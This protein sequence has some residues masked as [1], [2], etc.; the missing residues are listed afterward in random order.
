MLIQVFEEVAKLLAS[1]QDKESNELIN[2]AT[3]F[4]EECNS[5]SDTQTHREY[6]WFKNKQSLAQ[7]KIDDFLEQSSKFLAEGR[8][9]CKLLWHATVLDVLKICQ[10]ID[11]E[12]SRKLQKQIREDFANYKYL[13]SILKA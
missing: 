5:R 4:L 12:I 13:P 10:N 9:S 7:G 3:D 6:T 2:L 8:G 1:C 11:S